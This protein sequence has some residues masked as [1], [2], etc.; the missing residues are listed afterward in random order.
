MPNNIIKYGIPL[1]SIKGRDQNVYA[2]INFLIYLIKYDEVR[3][4]LHKFN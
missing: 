2:A 3:A 4:F 1:A